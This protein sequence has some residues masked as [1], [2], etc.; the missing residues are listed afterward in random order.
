M[1]NEVKRAYSHSLYLLDEK[2]YSAAKMREKLL[3]SYTPE[4]AEIVLNRL[5]TEGYINDAKFAAHAAEYMAEVK[6]FGAYRIKQELLSKGIDKETAKTAAARFEVAD[7]E[8]IKE[9]IHKKYESCLG[10]PAGERK[11][12]T[13]MARYGFRFSD[14]VK[15]IREMKEGT[16]KELVLQ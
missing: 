9:R 8:I 14:V 7:I 12:Q 4:T 3:N 11:I 13:A 5:I 2:S 15:A 10:T 16:E 1:D 6:R